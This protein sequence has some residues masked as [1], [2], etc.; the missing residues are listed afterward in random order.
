MIQNSYVTS[1]EF[2]FLLLASVIEFIN[3]K[4]PPLKTLNDG[5]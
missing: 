1:I 4:T 2:I 3:I 5:R